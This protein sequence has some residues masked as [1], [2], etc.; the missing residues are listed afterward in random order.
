MANWTS[1]KEGYVPSYQ[2]SAKPFAT[3]SISV[4]HTAAKEIKFPFVTRWV[5]VYNAHASADL[6]V[7]FSAFGVA[8]TN[9]IIVEAGKESGR[10]EVKCTSVFLSGAV[11]PS[12]SVC[13]GL[14]G[15]PVGRVNGLSGSTFGTETLKG[16]NW[17]GSSGVG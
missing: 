7:G 2:I 3:G 6:Y 17:S 14:T 15:I 5:Q 10:L 4:T 11:G 13:A 16:A 9:H 12:A 1:P 8:G